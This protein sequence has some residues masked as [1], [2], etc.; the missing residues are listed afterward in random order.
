ML[1]GGFYGLNLHHQFIP[2][3]FVLISITKKQEEIS[4]CA[5]LDDIL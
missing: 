1:C 2:F 4:V 5:A 3:A